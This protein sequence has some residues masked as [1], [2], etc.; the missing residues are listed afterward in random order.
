MGG[1]IGLD[2]SPLFTLLDRQFAGD[3]AG[4]QACF[5]DIQILESAA[6][7]KIRTTIANK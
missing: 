2:Y 3:P 1:Y 7:E 4:W 6:L 5:E